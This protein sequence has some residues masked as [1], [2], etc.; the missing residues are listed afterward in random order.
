MMKWGAVAG[1]VDGDFL[2]WA[3]EDLA[4]ALEMFWSWS[5]SVALTSS[6]FC[7]VLL[8]FARALDFSNPL[9]CFFLVCESSPPAAF[10]FCGLRTD[11]PKL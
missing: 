3:G 5:S 9:F 4:G 10:L 7:G 8:A 2:R 6:S 11:A 1:V